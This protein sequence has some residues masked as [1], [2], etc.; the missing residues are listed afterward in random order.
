MSQS[1]LSCEKA[2]FST[3]L[4]FPPFWSDISGWVD[5]CVN[6]WVSLTPTDSS[7]IEKWHVKLQWNRPSSLC[8][9]AGQRPVPELKAISKCSTQRLWW[10]TKLLEILNLLMIQEKMLNYYCHWF[11]KSSLFWT[12]IAI[13]YFS[14]ISPIFPDFFYA[15]K[16]YVVNFTH[17]YIHTPLLAPLP[18]RNALQGGWI[19]GVVPILR[20]LPRWLWFSL[21]VQ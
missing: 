14:D 3:T 4:D 6:R 12:K 13:Q 1:S 16:V 9:E 7:P 2:R 10:R 19:K 5:V 21:S 17:K 8:T 18:P 20:G 15:F 11:F